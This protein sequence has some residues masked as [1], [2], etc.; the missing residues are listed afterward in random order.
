M[1][2][3]HHPSEAVLVD[4]ASGAQRPAFAAV[5]A[6]H[7]EV[8]APCRSQV[9]LLEEVGGELLEDLAPA[10]MEDDGVAR[11]LHRL[12]AL[13]AAPP[14]RAPSRAPGRAMTDRIR[15][16]PRRWAGP[17]VW[18]RRAEKDLCGDDMLYMLYVPQGMTIFPH[19]HPGCEHIAV[20]KGGFTDVTGA[21][22]EGD[23]AEIAPD[24]E[25]EPKVDPESDCICLIASEH[26]MKMRTLFGR[27]FQFVAKI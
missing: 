1:N 13:E 25:H 26:P 7:L 11:L 24:V 27:M 20:V 22:A 15:F 17:G 10:A 19:N 8:C 18:V 6:A 2:P 9:R 3:Q 4:Y 21:Y 23:F 14:S 16:G 5:T 12:D